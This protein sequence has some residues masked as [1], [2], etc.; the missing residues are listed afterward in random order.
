MY[1]VL[2]SWH[3]G[4]HT[5]AWTSQ[6]IV[7]FLVSILVPAAVDLDVRTPAVYLVV[8]NACNIVPSTLVSRFRQF[9]LSIWAFQDAVDMFF[10]NPNSI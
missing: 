6:S 1:H 9:C 7:I 5:K 3:R 4:V 10:F 2:V 8:V